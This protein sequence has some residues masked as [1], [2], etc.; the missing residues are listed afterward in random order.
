MAPVEIRY[1][2]LLRVYYYC[3]GVYLYSNVSEQIL[4]ILHSIGWWSAND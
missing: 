2:L 1:E 4:G 3:L